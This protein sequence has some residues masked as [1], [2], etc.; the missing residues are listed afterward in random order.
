MSLFDLLANLVEPFFDL[1]PRLAHRP[2]SNE[3]LLVDPWWGQVRLS[4]QPW[5]YIPALTHVEYFPTYE[6]P[7]D[8]GVQRLTSADGKSVAV[9]ATASYLILNPITCR[10]SFG[11]GYDQLVALCI[12]GYVCEY[13]SGHNFDYLTEIL[14]SNKIWNEISLELADAGIKLVDFRVEDLQEVFPLSVLQ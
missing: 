10:D 14:D 6:L 4:S 9:N 12:R 7:L 8:C 1:I 3:S 5:V 13:V 2:A 11:D